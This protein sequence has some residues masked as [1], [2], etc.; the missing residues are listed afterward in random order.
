MRRRDEAHAEPRAGN[1]QNSM[2]RSPVPFIIINGTGERRK[3]YTAIHLPV[4]I[5]RCDG[6]ENPAENCAKASREFYSLS[7]RSGSQKISIVSPEI[8]KRQQEDIRRAQALW[9]EYKRR[10][11]EEN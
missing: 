11:K 4:R 5:R 3:A 1:G 2:A 7:D 8:K 10:K 9:I 6:L